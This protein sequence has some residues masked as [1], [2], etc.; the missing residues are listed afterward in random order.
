MEQSHNFVGDFFWVH[1]KIFLKIF[2][3][4]CLKF[5]YP[6]NFRRCYFNRNSY[7]NLTKI[8]EKQRKSM[9]IN[10]KQWKSMEIRRKFSDKKK[11]KI[12]SKI[13]SKI[14]FHEPKKNH[15][16]NDVIVPFIK[17]FTTKC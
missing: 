7:C 4:I 14:C 1:E 17:K 16:Q 11:S 6:R 12:F 3:K 8:C 10:E 5:F 2:L 15:L 9:E 13:F